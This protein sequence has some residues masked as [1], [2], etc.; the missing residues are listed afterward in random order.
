MKQNDLLAIEPGLGSG[1]ELGISW[2]ES[3]G[4]VAHQPYERV[5][6]LDR[7]EENG[8]TVYICRTRDP[9]DPED[10]HVEVFGVHSSRRIG[11]VAWR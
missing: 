3:D 11:I 9:E 1:N 4:P 2:R 7:R 5:S 10:L 6:V 8:C